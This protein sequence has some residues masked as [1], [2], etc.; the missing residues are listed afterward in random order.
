M[1]I[2]QG[3][4]NDQAEAVMQRLKTRLMAFI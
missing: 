1:S 2:A 3:L 4:I